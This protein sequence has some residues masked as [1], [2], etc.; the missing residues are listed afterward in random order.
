M[1]FDGVAGQATPAPLSGGEIN[2]AL[3]AF[4]EFSGKLLRK[5]LIDTAAFND[6]M[7]LGFEPADVRVNRRGGRLALQ[8]GFS[9]IDSS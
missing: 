1:N 9:L 8:H 6:G 2:D 4:A 3:P 7:V 5:R